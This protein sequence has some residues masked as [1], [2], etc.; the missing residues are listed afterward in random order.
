MHNGGYLGILAK[1]VQPQ[2]VGYFVCVLPIM[3]IGCSR[4]LAIGV[5]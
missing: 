4:V 2:P 1:G 3:C 5:Y